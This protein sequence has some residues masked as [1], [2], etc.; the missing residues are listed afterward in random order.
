MENRMTISPQLVRASRLMAWLSTLG[1]VLG[2]AVVVGCFLFPAATRALDIH[3]GHL[4]AELNDAVP[5]T[6]RIF[7]MLCALVPTAIASWGLIALAGLFRCFVAGQVFSAG[8]LRALSHVTMALFWNV[9][10]A[11]V[12]QAPISFFLS[13]HLGHGHRAVSLTLGSDDVQVLFVAGVAY[14]LAR[15]MAEARRIAD[16]NEG[17]V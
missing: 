14:V 17:F 6:D 7:A 10:A 1:A 8:A 13:Y 9:L 4:G 12:M 15:V 3:F 11:F 5:L 2:P 16:E